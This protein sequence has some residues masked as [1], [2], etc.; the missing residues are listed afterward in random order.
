LN[1][2]GKQRLSTKNFHI[3]QSIHLKMKEI[4]DIPDKNG[5]FIAIRC[6]LQ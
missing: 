2:A 3:Q 5:E 4:K 6:A 1:A